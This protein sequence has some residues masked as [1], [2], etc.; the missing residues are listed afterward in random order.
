MSD[1][2]SVSISSAVIE[3]V[4]GPK[5]SFKGSVKTDKPIR[6][7]GRYEGSIESGDKVLISE[8]GYFK[9]TLACRELELLGEAEG[10]V[11]C[12]ELFKFAVS[13][14][15]KGDAVAAN[16]DIKPGSRYDG[17]LLIKK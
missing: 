4:I 12:L 8:T 11:S 16:V 15:F 17:N 5:S 2:E 13:G 7:E 3:T 10:T 9:G 1:N 6:I 14:K